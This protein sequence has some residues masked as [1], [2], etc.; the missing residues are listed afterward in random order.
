MLSRRVWRIKL[1]PACPTNASP[2]PGRAIPDWPKLLHL[3]SRMRPGTTVFEWMQDYDVRSTG[4]DVRRFASFGV[5]KVSPIHLPRAPMIS[6]VQLAGF[7]PPHT[8]LADPPRRRRTT[9]RRQA[10]DYSASLAHRPPQARQQPNGAPARVLL[11]HASQTA[12]LRRNDSIR[13]RKRSLDKRHGLAPSSRG[14]GV[15]W[16]ATLARVGPAE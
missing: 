12:H 15:A 14:R 2:N 7:P 9:H 5:I 4:I 13:D 1:A 10:N 8:P 3:Y 11:F 6:H 16:H